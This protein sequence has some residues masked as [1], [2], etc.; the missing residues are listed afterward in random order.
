MDPAAAVASATSHQATCTDDLHVPLAQRHDIPRQC[1]TKVSRTT[2]MH[3]A[4]HTN[5]GGHRSRSHWG[6]IGGT[7]SGSTRQQSPGLRTAAACN[8]LWLQDTNGVVQAPS[9][10]AH[11]QWLGCVVHLSSL[12]AP[13]IHGLRL[14]I[15]QSQDCKASGKY[16]F[17]T[18]P[19]ATP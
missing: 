9:T 19:H 14:H 5:D 6:D 7:I 17:T 2:K 3:L 8:F 13:G 12:H 15:R 11:A 16:L 1:N 18:E 10:S 4:T